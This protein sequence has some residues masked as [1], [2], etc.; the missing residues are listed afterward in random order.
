MHRS[1][2]RLWTIS[3]SSLK[4][5]RPEDR[6]SKGG[7]RLRRAPVMA[8]LRRLAQSLGQTPLD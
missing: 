3:A 7:L 5:E 6:A 2:R 4:S 8:C 1:Q